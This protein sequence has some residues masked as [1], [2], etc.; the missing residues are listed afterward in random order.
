MPPSVLVVLTASRAGCCASLSLCLGWCAPV[1]FRAPARTSHCMAGKAAV[2]GPGGAALRRP[3]SLLSPLLPWV[4][5]AMLLRC[6]CLL[7]GGCSPAA[8]RAGLLGYYTS[9]VAAVPPRVCPGGLPLC[10]CSFLFLPAA[11]FLSLLLLRA[12]VL[13]LLLRAAVFLLLFRAAVLLLLLRAAVLLLLL[14]ASIC[15]CSGLQSFC[16]ISACSSAAV[17]RATVLLL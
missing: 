2:C 3:P 1:G 10:C 7:L 16:Y 6:G 12:A 11:V 13:L 14:R 5:A 8:R 9:P 15:C 4:A 17:L